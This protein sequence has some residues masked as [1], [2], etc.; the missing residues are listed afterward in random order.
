[1]SGAILS[2]TTRFPGTLDELLRRPFA[3][4]ALFCSGQLV[5]WTL[6]TSLTHFAPT[7]DM[8]ESYLW[9]HEWVIGTYKHPNMP[10]WL[11]E[12]GRVLTGAVGWPAY[13][14]SELF[15]I[16]TY[17]LVYALGAAMMG[18]ARALAGVLLLAGL[19]YTAWP[20]TL[21]NHD[22]A[23]MPI[24]VAV[25]LL[26]W[27]L[28]SKPTLAGWLAIGAVAALGLYAKLSF[29]VVIA[30]CG[31][32]ILYDP[33]LRR[34]LATL[35]PWL[36]LVL[37]A[38][39]CLPLASWLNDSQFAALDYARERGVSMGASPLE[40]LGGQ[41]LTSIGVIALAALAGLIHRDDSSLA[42]Q[43]LGRK[44]PKGEPVVLY[45]AHMLVIPN[46]M[47]TALAWLFVSGTRGMWGTPMLSLLGLLIVALVPARLDH[48]T[49]RRL[50]VIAAGVLVAMPLIYVTDTLL[51]PRLTGIPKRQGWPQVE[52]NRRFK[53]LWQQQ[54][55]QPLRIVA[56]NFWIAGLV[57]LSP[58]Q[59]PS[60]LTNGDTNLS[61]W[62]T[63]ERIQRQGVLVVWEMHTPADLPPGDLKL[64]FG[65]KPIHI[66]R[67][68]WPL[69][70]GAPPLLI[71]YAIVAPG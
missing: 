9:G 19:F 42:W 59:M 52:M 44:L 6:A 11:L 1:M 10:G 46:L 43:S 23:Q 51:E 16:A 55:G 58:G 30:S 12:A 3:V 28:R 18:P 22:V 49:S 26:L 29:G 39:C 34:Q 50:T 62:I 31:L 20:S 41:L 53:S 54:T 63:P 47:T 7:R 56:G 60:I 21:M 32:W 4:V 37:F 24:W 5:F 13:L 2:D 40:F 8:V 38:L 70:T 67:F 48:A 36:G 14:T 35:S 69:F 65:E 25:L 64:L 15:L 27:H 33:L 71:G 68:D 17:L 61:P 66:E 57:A 45:L